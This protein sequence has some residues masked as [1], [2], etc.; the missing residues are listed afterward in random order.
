MTHRCPTCAKS[1]PTAFSPCPH[2]N[3]AARR[4]HARLVEL[5]DEVQLVQ[6]RISSHLSGL[7]EPVDVVAKLRQASGL[8]LDV[9]RDLKVETKAD[10]GKDGK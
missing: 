7:T 4:R 1:L 6:S 5:R 3:G 8:L 9:A 2:C 10:G